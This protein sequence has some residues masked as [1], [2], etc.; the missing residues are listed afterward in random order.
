MSK[1]PP[2]EYDPIAIQRHMER[3]LKDLIKQDIEDLAKESEALGKL[4][5]MKKPKDGIIHIT[6]RDQVFS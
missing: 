2:K 3:T 6:T 1:G 4:L 5:R